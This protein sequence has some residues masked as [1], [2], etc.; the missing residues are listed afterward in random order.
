MPLKTANY[1]G[2]SEF[3][4]IFCAFEFILNYNRRSREEDKVKFIN[5]SWG[6]YGQ[7]YEMFTHY[8]EAVDKLD[9]KEKLTTDL[10]LNLLMLR[11]MLGI[12]LKMADKEVIMTKQN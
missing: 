5:A 8:M 12:G 7:E 2:E 10:G 9:L 11:V 1:R 6:Y 4:D 3:F